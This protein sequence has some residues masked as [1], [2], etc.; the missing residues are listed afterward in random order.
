M[1]LLLTVSF[2]QINPQMIC[3]T[4]EKQQKK[5]FLLGLP[6]L[7]W[8]AEIFFSHVPVYSTSLDHEPCLWIISEDILNKKSSRL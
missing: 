2:A 3:G 8:T 5:T 4:K 6:V 7:Q 1:L